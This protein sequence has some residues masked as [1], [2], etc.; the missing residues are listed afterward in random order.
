MRK[1]EL[2]LARWAKLLPFVVLYQ[3]VGC[4][5]DGALTQVVAENIVFTSAIFIQTLTSIFFNNL[6][7]I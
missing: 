3:T 5:P 4:L 2:K 7:L 6:F 1:A